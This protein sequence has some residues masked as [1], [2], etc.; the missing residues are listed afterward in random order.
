MQYYVIYL[1]F[2]LPLLSLFDTTDEEEEA[3]KEVKR[4]G[5]YMQQNATGLNQT[6]IHVAGRITSV[7]PAPPN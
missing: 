4:D 1:F 2:Y 3:E 5:D 7:Q 6:W